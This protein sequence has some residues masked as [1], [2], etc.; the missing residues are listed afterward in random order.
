VRTTVDG[1]ATPHPLGHMLPGLYHDNDLAQRFMGALDVVLAPVLASLDSID[2]YVDPRLA[3]LDFVEWLAGWV[4]VELDASWPESRQRALVARAGE[5]YAWRGTVRGVT[6]AV[7]IYTGV[8][9]EVAETGATVWTGEPPPS[10][11]LPG[12]PAGRLRVRVRVPPGEPI[13]AGRLDRLVAAAKP[14]HIAHEVEIVE[15]RRL[16]P[17][18]EGVPEAPVLAETEAGEALGGDWPAGDDD[19]ITVTSA[20]GIPPTIVPEPEEAGTGTEPEQTSD[21]GEPDA[22]DAD[23]GG[24]SGAGPD[25]GRPDEDGPG[26]EGS[27]DG[28]PP[29]GPRGAPPGPPPDVPP[30]PPSV[31]GT[32]GPGPMPDQPSRGNPPG[33]GP[34]GQRRSP[35]PPPAPRRPPRNDEPGG[36]G[37]Q[38]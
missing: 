36:P 29:E 35:P 22:G 18:V 19:G 9:P 13:D 4:G 25:D 14:A 5:L 28:P 6:E 34:S 30:A 24:P 23:D 16:R 10:G 31:R 15:D 33:G 38:G 17:S 37:G 12:S 20:R 11:Q 8:E 3:P 1:L 26:D 7:A 32:G 2:A 21:A 27:G